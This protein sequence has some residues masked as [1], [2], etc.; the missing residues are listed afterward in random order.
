M[1][2]FGPSNDRLATGQAIDGPDGGPTRQPRH[3][4]IMKQTNVTPLKALQN[5]QI[6]QIDDTNL[7]IELVGKRLVHYRH[8]KGQLKRVPISLSGIDKLEKYLNENK[9]V[10]T[11]A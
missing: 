11:N 6:W 4:E 9:A 7:R 8:Y 3:F 2:I 5:G 10:L 1:A